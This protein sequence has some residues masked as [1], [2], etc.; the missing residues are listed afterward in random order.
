MGAAPDETVGLAYWGAGQMLKLQ[1]KE[2]LSHESIKPQ[3]PLQTANRKPSSLQS[4]RSI[5]H[6]QLAN[7]NWQLAGP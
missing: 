4:Q 7:S 2:S 5:R 1:K 3:N 6:K